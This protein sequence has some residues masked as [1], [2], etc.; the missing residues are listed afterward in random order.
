MKVILLQDVKAL[1]R[2]GDVKEVADGY[3]RNFLFVKQLAQ[4][5]DKANMNS[6]SHENKLRMIREEQALE[7]AK[8]L[9]AELKEKTIILHAKAGEAGRLFGSVTTADVSAALAESGYN[10]DKKKIELPETVKK[11][12]SYKA[13]LKLHTNVHVEITLDV[14]AIDKA[15]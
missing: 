9:A 5:A 12:G 13:M 4:P 2:K 15:K 10:V 14:V 1:G 6:L 8:K 11:L 7:K 3:A